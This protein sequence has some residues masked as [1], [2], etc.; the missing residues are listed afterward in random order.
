MYLLE[1]DLILKEGIAMSGFCYEI[2]FSQ[3]AHR[4]IVAM[5]IVL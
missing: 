5:E 1:T 3:E 2:L 4:I